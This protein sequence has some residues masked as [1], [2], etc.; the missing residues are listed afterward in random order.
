M[1]KVEVTLNPPRKIVLIGQGIT[2]LEILKKLSLHK[3]LVDDVTLISESFRFTNTD[4]I[5]SCILGKYS[6]SEVEI[7]LIKMAGTAGVKYMNESV[8]QLDADRR[9]IYFETRPPISYDFLSINMDFDKSAP[10]FDTKYCYPLSSIENLLAALGTFAKQESTKAPTLS[11]VG[12]DRVAVESLLAIVSFMKDRKKEAHFQLLTNESCLMPNETWAVRKH[13]TKI[14][15]NNSVHM[16]FNKEILE[17]KSD[18]IRMSGSEIVPSHFTIANT[19]NPPLTFLER[20]GLELDDPYISVTDALQSLSHK[21]VFASGTIAAVEGNRK[22]PATNQNMRRQAKT[23]AENIFRALKEDRLS[24]FKPSRIQLSLLSGD[25]ETVVNVGA[26]YFRSKKISRLKNRMEQRFMNQFNLSKLAVGQEFESVD[27][28]LGGA[29]GT[30]PSYFIN[31]SLSALN[32]GSQQVSVE[33]LINVESAPFFS[34]KPGSGVVQ[35]VSHM[36]NFL[37]DPFLMGSVCTEHG[38]TGIYARGATPKT[39]QATIVLPREQPECEWNNT[40][41][42][43]LSGIQAKLLLADCKLIAAHARLGNELAV[44]LVVN[45]TTDEQNLFQK[46]SAQVNQRLIVTKPLGTGRILSALKKNK[47]SFEVFNQMTESMTLSNSKAAEIFKKLGGTAA[48]DI[49]GFGLIGSLQE[50]LKKSKVSASLDLDKIPLLKTSNEIDES[51]SSLFLSNLK[52]ADLLPKNLDELLRN[53]NFDLLFD[54]ETSGG[55]LLSID[56][57]QSNELISELRKNGYD[58]AQVFGG[59]REGPPKITFRSNIA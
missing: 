56:S 24:V 5:P 8:Q 59:T 22:M 50:L 53:K 16:Y 33:G 42:Q 37:V 18:Q 32:E 20:S 7:D 34:L 26:V 36:T 2:H 1:N 23:V 10:L 30:A 49:G 27:S 29:N 21:S 44:D 3:N 48:I 17:V 55:L 41:Y 58:F 31:N 12:C 19:K 6:P 14:L 51:N 13:F 52:A 39:A 46:S 57:N 54:P 15:N 11:I 9:L 47:I 45:G 35:S 25:N 40:L 43:V 4:M 28:F 38:L